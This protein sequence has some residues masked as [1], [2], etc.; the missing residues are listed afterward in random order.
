LHF[1]KLTG[2]RIGEYSIRLNKQWRL[3]L[4]IT[5]DEDG[6]YLVILDIEVTCAGYIARPSEYLGN[7]DAK[8]LKIGY[9]AGQS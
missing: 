8:S 6:N 5:S 1:E 7:G 9:F 2:D 3:T 4:V